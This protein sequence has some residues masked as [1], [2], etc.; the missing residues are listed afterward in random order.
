MPEY[1]MRDL[2]YYNMFEYALKRIREKFSDR[3][4]ILVSPFK[5][6]ADKMV[7]ITID[8]NTDIMGVLLKLSKYSEYIE[9]P[10]RNN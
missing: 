3:Y 9:S 10:E 7:N 8:A 4:E 5:M 1:V 2:K 6:Q